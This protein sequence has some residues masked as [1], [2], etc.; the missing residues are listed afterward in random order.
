MSPLKLISGLTGTREPNFIELLKASIKV[1]SLGKSVGGFSSS[2]DKVVYGTIHCDE[3]TTDNHVVQL[4]ANII[5][6][7]KSDAYPV[8][9]RFAPTNSQILIF[10]GSENLPYLLRWRNIAVDVSQPYIGSTPITNPVFYTTNAS[11][12]NYTYPITNGNTLYPGYGVFLIVP[13]IW[14]PYDLNSSSGVIGPSS[15]RIVADNLVTNT[16]PSTD[17]SVALGG[18]A[19]VSVSQAVGTSGGSYSPAFPLPAFQLSPSS[20]AIYNQSYSTYQNL[21]REPMCLRTPGIGGWTYQSPTTL[22]NGSFPADRKGSTTTLVTSNGVTDWR[23]GSSNNIMGIMMGYFPLTATISY[24]G[25]NYAIDGNSVGVHWAGPR[26]NQDHLTFRMQYLDAN[27]VWRDYDV[28]KWVNTSWNSSYPSYLRGTGNGTFSTNMTW[29]DMI[30]SGGSAYVF[31]PRTMRF[32]I[33]SAQYGQGEAPFYK[34]PNGICITNT[35]ITTATQSNNVQIGLMVT[36]LAK[37]NNILGTSH[38]DLYGF[39]STNKLL[40]NSYMNGFISAAGAGFTTVL[41]ASTVSY[42]SIMDA[43]FCINSSNRVQVYPTNG[44]WNSSAWYTDPDGVQRMAMGA[45]ASPG[46]TNAGATST[47]LGIPTITATANWNTNNAAPTYQ[48][49]SR[50]TMLHRPFR[51]VAEL[52]YVFRDIPW[53]NIDFFTPESGD[54]GLLDAFCIHDSSITNALAAGKVNLNT[55]QAPVLL[56]LLSGSQT[57]QLLMSGTNSYT[58][59]NP[60][61]LIS[62][63]EMTN[64]ANRLVSRTATSSLSQIGDL[65]GQYQGGGVYSGFSA[66]LT[67]CYTN[68]ANIYIQR[69]HESAIR[70]LAN[71]GQTRVWNI[72]IDVIAQPGFFPGSATV[73]SSFQVQ[74]ERRWW[75]HLAIDRITDKVIDCQIEPVSE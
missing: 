36:N 57:D 20:S 42:S 5:E 25:T 7:A 31:D 63:V 6:Q 62:P 52:G 28:K 39:Q 65:V 18:P 71:S 51:S 48:S 74:G 49:Q 2:S 41:N 32:G 72:L 45:Y 75:V 17:G 14:N 21:F 61:V 50:P 64:I 26:H 1:G 10:A 13:E 60:A 37:S 4:A 11:S 73:L 70:S 46:Y 23:D 43:G 53:K 47:N 59:T 27:S 12:T 3:A 54:A 33:N 69:F 19:N 55:R 68:P 66:D 22:M 8:K 9:I 24:N 15:I 67:N 34:F 16:M 44:G 38:Y 35:Y 58:I 30:G 40:N 29:D 56:A